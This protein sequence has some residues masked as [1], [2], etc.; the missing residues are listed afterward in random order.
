MTGDA[1]SMGQPFNY[2]EYKP[3]GCG[4]PVHL[5]STIGTADDTLLILCGD[6]RLQILALPPLLS[7]IPIGGVVGGG[8]DLFSFVDGGLLDLIPIHDLA[9]VSTWGFWRGREDQGSGAEMRGW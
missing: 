9:N 6:D 8:R 3:R 1:T 7:A 4:S 5:C 2:S